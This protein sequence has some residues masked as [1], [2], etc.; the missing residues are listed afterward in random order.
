MRHGALPARRRILQ[1]FVKLAV[2]TLHPF[3]ESL[4]F[5]LFGIRQGLQGTP[6][7]FELLRDGRQRRR[8]YAQFFQKP[9]LRL[10]SWY[11]VK[12]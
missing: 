11:G 12:P 5:T 8:T 3:A 9:I 2:T 10:W 6:F 7:R 1:A 4:D